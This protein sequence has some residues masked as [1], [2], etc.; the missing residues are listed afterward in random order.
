M[1]S[2]RFD[3]QAPPNALSTLLARKQAAGQPII[4]LTQS[5]PTRVGLVYDDAAILAALSMP[6]A[7]IYE[8]DARGLSSARRAVAD[9][10]HDKGCVIDPD[11]LFLTASTS[12]AYSLLFKLLGDP[13]DEVLI[14][15]PGYPLLAYLARFEGLRAVAYPLRYDEAVGWVADREILQALITS[16]TR[17]VVV[18]SP[19]NPTGS[20]LKKNELAVLDHLC[21]QRDLALIVDEVFA[22]FAAPQALP[23]RFDTVLGQG[24][25]LT[26][27]LNGFSKLLALPQIKLGWIAV[28]GHDRLAR[29]ACDRLETLID[30]YLPVSAPVQH[31]VARLLRLRGAIQRQI[32]D[33]IAANDGYL[34]AQAAATGNCRA[35]AREGGWYA[36]VAID[37]AISD[38]ARVVQ[39]LDRHD[40]LVHPGYFYDFNREG[41]VVISLLPQEETFRPGVANLVAAFGTS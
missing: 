25:A 28:G 31:G 23:E 8:P 24:S 39:L 41:Y 11:R 26:F 21:C 38:E 5:N 2:H 29:A 13:D 10:Y 6:A 32:Q 40:T 9:Y 1:F 14:P 12:E 7:L 37:D 20:C 3:W 36:V 33:R 19:N 35:L 15:A 22:D 17:A 34:R 30:F 4:D 18:V 27:V 16:K